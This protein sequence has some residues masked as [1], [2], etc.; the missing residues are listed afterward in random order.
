MSE[1]VLYILGAGFSAPLGLPIMS[2]FMNRA[3]DIFCDNPKEMKHIGSY[4]RKIRDLGFVRN[5]VE[6][7]Y[8]NIEDILSLIE[9]QALGNA[10]Q[11]ER[12]DIRRFIADVINKS[13][14]EFGPAA[15]TPPSRDDKIYGNFNIPRQK[16]G[17]NIMRSY[18]YG[19][20]VANLI[21]LI[22]GPDQDS[23]FRELNICRDFSSNG[24]NYAVITFNYD[25]VIEKIIER[26]I[27]N[28][29]PTNTNSNLTIIDKY[30]NRVNFFKD[31]GIFTLAKLHG[32][33]SEPSSITPP[34]SRKLDSEKMTPVWR[35]SYNLIAEANHIRIIGYSMP[36]SDNHFRFLLAAGLSKSKNL[37]SIDIICLDENGDVRQRFASVINHKHRFVNGD[38]AEYLAV[39]EEKSKNQHTADSRIRECKFEH[40]EQA[41]TEYIK[42]Y[43]K[44]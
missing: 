2:N 34:T 41:H 25:T 26:I 5:Y 30:K 24:S 11:K 13:M 22:V 29:Y 10:R 36:K 12:V 44:D 27:S 1:N 37:K 9:M 4:L 21:K 20:F 23:N 14:P 43:L 17:E 35:L 28:T 8:F 39:L 31:Q 16:Y 42:T 40:L 32:T 6:F 19:L 38:V 15:S 18:G 3:R 33:A 7:D